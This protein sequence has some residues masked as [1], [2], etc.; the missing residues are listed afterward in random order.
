MKAQKNTYDMER[1]NL[2]EVLPLDTPMRVCIEPT[3]QCNLRCKY[4][5]RALPHEELKSRGFHFNPMDMQ[6][7]ELIANQLGEFSNKIKKVT[8]SGYGEPLLNERLPEMIA[9]IKQ[10]DIAEKILVISN[11][12]LLTP[13]LGRKLVE[14]GL[15]ELKIS[16]QGIDSKKYKE[17]SGVS[18]DYS[19]LYSNISKFYDIRRNCKLKVKIADCALETGDSEIFYR[20]YGNICD[21][22]SI[23]HI[24]PAFNG[25]DYTNILTEGIKHKNRFGFDIKKT[26]AC[27]ALFY[28]LNVLHNGVVTFGVCDGITYDGFNINDM[29]LKKMWDSYERKKLLF[30]QLSGD[31]IPEYCRICTRWD[32]LLVPEDDIS[33][34]EKEILSRMGTPPTKETTMETRKEIVWCAN[35]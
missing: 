5:L 23:E 22:I 4:C 14:A 17:V 3:F 10:K 27:T 13:E 31:C 30:N 20:Q 15:T 19:G 25:V 9:L 33:G 28:I 26:P 11:G 21:Y 1:I 24:Y 34:H 6:S 7:F 12:L 18:I 29:T 16:L 32:Y 2:W 8:F 35:C